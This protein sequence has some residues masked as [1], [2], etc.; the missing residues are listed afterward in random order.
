MELIATPPHDAA[1][2]ATATM[3]PSRM[4]ALR[5]EAE[6]GSPISSFYGYVVDGSAQIETRTLQV[7]GQAGT[8]FACPG[9]VQVRADGLT[10]VIERF[11]YRCLAQAG[12]VEAQGRLAYIDGCSDSVLVA[13]ARQG[14][15]VLNLLHFPT[16]VHQS[17]H[18]H[19]SIRLGVVAGG[20]GFAFGPGPGGTDWR[21]ALQPGSMFL[22]PAHEMHAFS[23]AESGTS[24][25][26]IAFHPDSDWGPTDGTHPMLNRTYLR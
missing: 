12:S 20:S 10:V 22:L 13:P 25:D 6:L 2:D 7:T 4:T 24:L 23:T 16:G 21:L 14:D 1:I 9:P 3:Y 19:P 18:S 8:Y 26:I 15:P 11:G 17:V 5:G